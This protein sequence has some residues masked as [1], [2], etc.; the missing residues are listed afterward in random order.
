[1]KRT[2]NKTK[3]VQRRLLILI[4]IKT[5][6]SVTAS[7]PD[8]DR[9]RFDRARMIAGQLA[10]SPLSPD[11]SRIIFRAR[12][13]LPSCLSS[14]KDL[15]TLGTG[16]CFAAVSVTAVRGVYCNTKNKMDSL[17]KWPLQGKFRQIWVLDLRF[18]LEANSTRSRPR[19]RQCRVMKLMDQTP[20]TRP[21]GKYRVD[22]KEHLIPTP[23]ST[24]TL[25]LAYM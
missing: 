2:Q 10:T 20:V 4:P 16:F 3:I 6:P 7:C 23:V 5:L 19:P 18:I 24:G 22:K 11:T 21:R 17:S 25:R 14:A 8:W 13:S 1:M 9:T 12:E 15:M